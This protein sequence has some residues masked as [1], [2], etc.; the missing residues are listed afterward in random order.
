MT[1]EEMKALMGKDATDDQINAALK[2]VNAAA[3]LLVETETSGLLTNKEKLLT[4]MDKLK[5]NQAPEGYDAE[6]YTNFIKE[7][8]EF[9]KKKKELE[10][11]ELEGKG[12]WEALKLK[13]NETH[14]TALA[15]V[16]DETGVT[17]MS[18]QKALDKE[19]IENN[20][21]KAIETEKGNSLFLLPHM[22]GQ[23]KTVLGE[24]GNY[25]VQV[26]DKE[27]KQRFAD[28]ATT[29]F[30]VKDLVAEFKANDSYAPAFP[31]LNTG[32]GGNPDTGG[33]G[34]TGVNPWK[35]DTKNI[36]EQA[37]INK[38]NPTLATQM[39]KA[40]GVA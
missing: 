16:T 22:R 8:E 18:L 26:L 5:K 30:T 10:D 14:V 17:I 28:D 33:K 29:P 37:R 27:G 21:I 11:A 31:D 12:Q 24:D 36:T 1:F 38:E 23:M 7:S 25:S 9:D 4:Q 20:A 19:L 13:L 35:T 15:K 34:G 2:A 6:A 39:K 32:S 40:A 3:K